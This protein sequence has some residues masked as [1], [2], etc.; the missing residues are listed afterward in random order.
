MRTTALLSRRFLTEYGRNTANLLLLV[1]VPVTFV[2][3]A[4]PALADAAKLLGGAA[5]G[6]GIETVTAGWAASFL[7][8]VAMYF[9]VAD[10]RRADRRLLGCG[11]PRH[12]LV[13]ARL[14]V[15]VTLATLASAAALL[16][17]AAR[18]GIDDPP[19]VIAGT[20]LFALIYVGLGAVVGA[21]VPTA[22]NGTVLVLF[23]WILDVFFGPTL[24]GGSDSPILRVLPT[25]YVSLWLADLPAGHEGP[26]TLT[27]SLVW[28]AG[29]VLAATI[30]VGASVSPSRGR[31]R[32]PPGRWSQ[33]RTGLR[34]GWHDWRRTPVLWVLLAAVPAVF[35]LLSVPITPHGQAPMRLV[36]DGVSAI[37]I[38][39]PAEIHPGTM[40]PIAIGSLATLA[41]V[42]IVLD[43]RAADRRLALAG[44]RVPA[45]LAVRL[46]LV[47][48]AAGIST[49]VTLGVTATV[50][51]AHQWG[52]YAAGNALVAVMY[53]LIGV[54][55]G[56]IFGRVSSVFL[57]FVIPFLDLGIWQSPMLR[58][59]P[60]P[61]SQWLPGYGP[62]RIVLDGGLTDSF[63][64]TRSLALALGWTALFLVL[65]ITVLAPRVE[66][67]RHDRAHAAH[68]AHAL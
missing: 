9:Q 59:E 18:N 58:V 7:S 30:V 15:G 35:V 20:L 2:L 26:S 47:L 40:A 37:A 38:V 16:A 55:L 54:V 25:H 28:A 63:D 51:T 53:A 66:G 46:L 64:E 32:R 44:F 41:G 8:A 12:R 52:T 14:V 39:D 10:S 43:S 17:L 61:W 56:P 34:A 24:S 50:F 11:L 1:L 48:A 36:E 62:V 13:I 4:A 27:W 45:L 3:S 23:V 19:R 22:I 42:F 57:A 29:A 31:A 60:E 68:P 5:G 21:T 33:L 49:A 65:A 67:R 6:T